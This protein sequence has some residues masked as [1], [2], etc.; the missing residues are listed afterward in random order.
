M[1]GVSIPP[2]NP[3]RVVVL[4]SSFGGMTAALEVSKH[5]DEVVEVVV[6]DPRP[7]SASRAS[8]MPS[9]AIRAT[10]R[11]SSRTGASCRPRI[12]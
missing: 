10:V 9:S 8:R 11:S 1:S 2:T 7:D 3:H 4:G 6:L 5:L 12:R